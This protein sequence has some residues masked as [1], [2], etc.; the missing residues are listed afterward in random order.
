MQEASRRTLKS[1]RGRRSSMEGVVTHEK[2]RNPALSPLHNFGIKGCVS[3]L[4]GTYLLVVVGPASVIL[5]PLVS[6][7]GPIA[8]C[9]VALAFGGTV[10]LVIILFGT[11]SGAI[12]NPAL[13]LAA[14]SARLLNSRLVV[15]YIVSQIS[16]GVLAG[17]TLKFIFGPIAGSA[18]L[19]STKLATIVPPIMGVVLEALG[20]FALASSALV[21]AKR[22]RKAKYQALFVGGTLAILI[23]LVGPF[24]GAGFNPARSLGPSLA[25]GY[26]SNLY[27]YIVGPI[28]GALFA[29]FLFGLIAARQ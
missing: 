29:G 14:A 18:N 11:Y 22:V 12:I 24:T 15:P 5:L 2:R 26:F 16:G 27:V 25:A 17:F 7:T 19:G 10:S 13:T 6:I 23:L 1:L 8:L 9:M 21:A 4:V 28:I 20:T 3:E